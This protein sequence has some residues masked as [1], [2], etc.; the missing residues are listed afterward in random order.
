MRQEIE[1]SGKTIRTLKY[2]AASPER[3]SWTRARDDAADVE[4][5]IPR[6]TVKTDSQRV[7]AIT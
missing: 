7:K 2:Q 3:S 5:I 1:V 6:D 4:V